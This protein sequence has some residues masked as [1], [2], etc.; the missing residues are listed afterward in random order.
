MKTITN[1]LHY[2]VTTFLLVLT[3]FPFYILLITSL[4][5]RAEV[6]TNF[7]GLPSVLR[8]ENYVS[9]FTQ[10]YPFI[11]N[12]LFVTAF[13]I[14]GV[15]V[16]S[17]LA[18]YS[19]SRF[20]YPGK[21]VLFFF[22]LSQ[23]MIPGFLLLIPQF[24][25]IQRLGLLN[26]FQGLIYPPTAYVASIGTLLMTT[27]Y[28]GLPKSLYEAAEIEGAKEFQIFSMIVVPLT[29]PVAATVSVVT[30]L[31]SWNNYIW[32]LVAT[33]GRRVRP[34][35]LALEQ[36]SFTRQQGFSVQLAGYVIA[37]IPLLILFTIATKPFVSGLTAGALKG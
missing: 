26:T 32:P 22:V 35:I 25:L 34:V 37:A 4:K 18:G 17:S 20:E 11:L 2:F 36:V 19:F 15:V 28:Q 21:K 7:W 14:A 8:L 12:S 31:L 16:I 27:F 23:L 3:L 13:T 9:A 24:L 33:S 1:T 6:I 29:L 5:N 30:G 10:I